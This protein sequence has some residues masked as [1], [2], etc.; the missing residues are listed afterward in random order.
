MVSLH[1]PVTQAS[2]DSLAIGSHGHEVVES[3]IDTAQGT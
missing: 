2:Y 1:R 3:A